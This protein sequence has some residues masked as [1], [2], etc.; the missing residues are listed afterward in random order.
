M[1]RIRRSSIC[2][3]LILVLLLGIV[4]AGLSAGA[5][6][7]T[8]ADVLGMDGRAY[9]TWLTRHEKDSYYLGTT[10]RGGDYRTPHGSDGKGG[11]NELSLKQARAEWRK[12]HPKAK[13]A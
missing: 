13:K 4:P 1:K 8:V 3:M 9:I 2:L 10:Y 7:R 11:A 6:T 5:K 12:A